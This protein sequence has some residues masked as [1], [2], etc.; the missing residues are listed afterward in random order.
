MADEDKDQRTA[1]PGSDPGTEHGKVTGAEPVKKE[2][3]SDTLTPEGEKSLPFDKDP[4]WKAARTAEK[5]LQDIMAANEIENLE[6]LVQLVIAGKE[7]KGKQLNPDQLDSLLK[8]A[9]TLEKYEAYWQQQEE[10]KRRT[11]EE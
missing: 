3:A 6:D 2:G 4:K 9:Q 8:K 5:A 1:D 10:I 11:E 7:L